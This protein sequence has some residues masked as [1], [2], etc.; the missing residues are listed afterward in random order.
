MKSHLILFVAS[1]ARAAT[2]YARVLDASPVLD[3]PGMTEFALSETSRLV[4]AECGQRSADA[5]ANATT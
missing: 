4:D 5:A 1:Q 2:F 3:V